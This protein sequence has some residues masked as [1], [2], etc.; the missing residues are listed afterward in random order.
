MLGYTWQAAYSKAVGSSVHGV[1][2]GILSCDRAGFLP[3]Q[4]APRWHCEQGHLDRSSVKTRK[5]HLDIDSY[6][7]IVVDLLLSVC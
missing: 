6:L 3:L 5:Q 4:L 2:D 7:F 1:S